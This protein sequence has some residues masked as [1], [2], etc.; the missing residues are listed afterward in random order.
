MTKDEMMQQK[1]IT[2]AGNPAK[3]TGEAGEKMLARMNESHAELTAWGLSF[4]HWQ[5]DEDVLDI[6]CG[7]G[8]NLH[9]MSSHIES[10][11]LTGV[12]YAK[13][14]VET[15]RQTNADD[16]AAGKMTVCEGSVEALPFSDDEFDKITTVE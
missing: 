1:K 4:F 13:T 10:G 16:I 14:S 6:G 5:G 11:H 7:G 12:D 2:T 3:P 15:S 9:R 8:A